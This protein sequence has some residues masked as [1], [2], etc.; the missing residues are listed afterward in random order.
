MY[1]ILIM[2]NISVLTSSLHRCRY[3]GHDPLFGDGL[4][5]LSQLDQNQRLYVA[6]DTAGAA[7]PGPGAG[8]C[9]L[10]QG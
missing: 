8:S 3:H 4:D 7:D 10:G 1:L 5:V 9:Q 6:G 2:I